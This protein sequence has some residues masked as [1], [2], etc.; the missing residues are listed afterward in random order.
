MRRRLLAVIMAFTLCGIVASQNVKAG[1]AGDDVYVDDGYT[2]E[3]TDAPSDEPDDVSE[4]STGGDINSY[5]DEKNPST[6]VDVYWDD[7]DV[8]TEATTLVVEDITVSPAKITIRKGQ[9]FTIK[10][11]AVGGSEF[12]DLSEEEWYEL[13]EDNLDS[14]KFRSSKSSVVAVGKTGK[15]KGR[16]RGSAVIRTT[17]N[18]SNGD[19]RTFKTKVYVKK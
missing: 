14:I 1:E 8:I 5:W 17:V 6:D 3:D 2:S 18:L 16:K 11:V 7:E 13:Y 9:A 15:V 19:S 10:V 4:S 12:D